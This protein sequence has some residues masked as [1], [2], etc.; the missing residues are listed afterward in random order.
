VY[1]YATNGTSAVY[2]LQ[3]AQPGLK[4]ILVKKIARHFMK[5]WRMLFQPSNQ[6]DGHLYYE[7]ALAL[8]STDQQPAKLLFIQMH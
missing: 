8:K 1:H 4:K 5:K 7:K 6:P 3:L 2:Y